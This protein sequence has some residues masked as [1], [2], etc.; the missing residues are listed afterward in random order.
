MNNYRKSLELLRHDN[1]E[2][3]FFNKAYRVHFTYV[4]T[5]NIASLNL[6]KDERDGVEK[7]FKTELEFVKEA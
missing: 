1:A 2:D 3:H 5:S 7:A 4:V 6:K